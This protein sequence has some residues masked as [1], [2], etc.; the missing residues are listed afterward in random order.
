MTSLSIVIWTGG[1]WERWGPPSLE[2]GIGGSET[3][4][5]HMARELAALG[6]DVR[7]VGDHAGYEG[8]YPRAPLARA[9]LRYIDYKKVLSGEE[10]LSD[11]DILISS[12]DKRAHVAPVQARKKIL[13]VHDL[14]VGDDWNKDLMNFD[15]IFC[16]SN[17]AK[18]V[19]LNYYSHIEPSKIYV[20]RNGIN[21]ARYVGEPLKDNNLAPRFFYSSSPDRGLDVL[22]FLWPK[23]REFTP[24][25]ELHV[26]YGFDTWEKMAEQG[27][28][29]AEISKVAYFKQLVMGAEER[30]IFYHGRVGQRKL[31]EAQVVSA[32]WLYPTAFK[33]TFCITALEAQ[34]AGA[35]PVTTA[36]GGL[37]ETVKHG[38]LIPPPNTS[39]A[40]RDTFVS[41]VKAMLTDK[42]SE[43]LGRLSS[44]RYRGREWALTQTWKVLAGDWSQY[45]EQLL[46]DGVT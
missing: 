46:T 34:A 36:L 21:A 17:Y 12:R 6:H 16:L 7:C 8:D 20:T 29:S 35:I 14:H 15:R 13:W 22:L 44:I 2:F 19:F 11:C 5:I 3:A 18:D 43:M 45:F 40:Y 26:Y 9:H 37:N 23:I 30:G 31:A 39:A 41:Y 24:D 42:S 1:A 27:K 33:E 32:L 28:N 10:R 25:A 38:V 4:V